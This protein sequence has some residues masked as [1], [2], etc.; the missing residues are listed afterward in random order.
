[1]IIYI[2]TFIFSCFCCFLIQKHNKSKILTIVFS[3][4]SILSLS[5]IGGMRDLTIGTDIAVYGKWYFNI[6]CQYSSLK[7]Y[8]KAINSDFL[9]LL[10][11]FIVSRFTKDINIFL[12]VSQIIVNSLV[13][14]T[15]YKNREHCPMWMAMLVYCTIYYCRNYNFLRQSLAL[16]IIF[17]SFR[18]LYSKNIIKYVICVVIAGLFHS[19][20]YIAILFYIINYIMTTKSKKTQI[21][22]SYVVIFFSLFIVVYIVETL[23][24]LNNFNLLNERYYIYTIKYL[25]NF[26]DF[27]L[28]ETMFRVLFIVWYIISMKK[29]NEY[30]KFNKT[31]GLLIILDCILIQFKNTLQ[32]SERISYYFGYAQ[33]LLLPQLTS[34]LKTKNQ[35][36]VFNS[37]L[38]IVLFA[39]FYYEFVICRFGAAYPY[40]SSI[41]GI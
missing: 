7:G 28:I 29:I 36:I 41:L 22:F 9:Y 16:A 19:S 35:K 21:I 4:L 10:L 14:I 1:M 3:I 40:T 24:I 2:I 33:I 26:T 39:Y 20:A 32:Y 34:V 27:Y 37:I 38:S 17:Y 5:F 31:L 8:L 11:N 6:A 18:Y 25:K 12:F 23:E 13:F 15:I 30:D